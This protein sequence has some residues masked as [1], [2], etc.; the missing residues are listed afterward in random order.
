MA[1]ARLEHRRVLLAAEV[2]SA[3]ARCSAARALLKLSE[4]S[5]V[6]SDGALR[7]AEDGR[8]QGREPAAAV[9]Q[10][11]LALARARQEHALLERRLARAAGDL[12]VLLTDQGVAFRAVGTG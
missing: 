3:F 10:A 4:G 9:E 1:E 6:A 2:R 5:G 12:L 11:R 7:L 8:T